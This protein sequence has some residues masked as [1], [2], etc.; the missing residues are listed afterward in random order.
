MKDL[1]AD[2]PPDTAPMNDLDAKSGHRMQLSSEGAEDCSPARERWEINRARSAIPLAVL[3]G[4]GKDRHM[5]SPRL[6]FF[7]S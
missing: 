4:S 3:R 2:R 7:S 5:R 1:G 6:L